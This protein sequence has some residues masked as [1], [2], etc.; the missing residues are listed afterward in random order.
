MPAKSKSA[1]S[2]RADSTPGTGSAARS[3]IIDGARRHFLAHG[4]RSVTMDDLAAELGMSKKTLYAHFAS[5]LSLLEA[6]LD[7]KIASA[8]A[9]LK[10]ITMGEATAFQPMLRELL[11]CLQ[12]HASELS[13]MFVR[14]M[15]REAPG[16]FLHVQNERKKLI[17]RYFGA[18]FHTGQEQGMIRRDIPAEFLIEMLIGVTQAIMNPPKVEELGITPKQGFTSIIS[19][20]LEG[21]LTEKGRKQ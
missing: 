21:A 14:D 15:R 7:D 18:F 10:S 12:R 3:Q 8:D 11:A 20:I 17:Q 1:P 16:I 5:K 4:F 6:V 13:P 19:V 9:D 2:S